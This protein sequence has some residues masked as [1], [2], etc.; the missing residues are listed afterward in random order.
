MSSRN[1][2]KQQRLASALAAKVA[3]SK[4]KT[5][6]TRDSYYNA[7]AGLGL[8]NSPLSDSQTY[9]ATYLS[10]NRQLLENMYCS[11][12]ICQRAVDTFSDD[13][14]RKGINII[15]S[16]LTPDDISEIHKEWSTL[17]IWSKL[18]ETFKWSRL[19]GGCIAV[20]LIDG[21]DMETPL[22][23]KKISKGQFKGL[24]VLDRWQCQ[25]SVTDIVTE[26]GPH[27]GRPKFYQ[28]TNSASP[29]FNK[30]IHWSRAIQIDGMDVPYFR[31]QSEN[32][33]GISVF[34][35]IYERITAF[36]STTLGTAQLAYRAYLRT[37]KIEG[38]RE[39]VA[40]GGPPLAGVQ[41]QLQF[42]RQTQ[43]SEGITVLDSTDEFE[44]HTYTF[45]GLDN[46]L[47][48][49]ASQVAGA[50]GIPVTRLFGTSSKGLNA[51]GEGDLKNYHEDVA[52]QQT[53]KLTN[54]INLLVNLTCMSLFGEPSPD[55]MTFSFRSLDEL[56]EDAK[57]TIAEKITKSIRMMSNYIGVQEA[58]AELRESSNVTGI[59]T[60]ID[61]TVPDDIK[62]APMPMKGEEDKM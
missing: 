50:C 55:D 24:A 31:K 20:V 29:L 12:F 16:K 62:D 6:I 9:T 28:V 13:S 22:D 57:A 60:N 35:R 39:I 1:F 30:K 56:T 40:A 61:E 21:Q 33:W 14:T 17:R 25:P 4:A 45:A 49:F 48:Q 2:K 34:E 44:T 5:T 27:F 15:S 52:Q 7:V 32:G 47:E 26:F 41:A 8:G 36:D 54:G 3:D 59:F 38:L 46:I 51:T 11:S 42:M 19:Y 18:N 58:R 53:D 23:V 10:H 43:S 37:M